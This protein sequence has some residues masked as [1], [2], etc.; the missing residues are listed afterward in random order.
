[1]ADTSHNA[2]ATAQEIRDRIREEFESS[3]YRDDV[4]N[5][6]DDLAKLREDIQHIGQHLRD[7]GRD[8]GKRA[9]DRAKDT[10]EHTRE[11]A[12]ELRD[13]G[14]EYARERIE[15]VERVA[16]EHPLATAAALL[17]AGVILGQLLSRGDRR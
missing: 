2:K 13:R 14:E 11:R 17:G 16:H 15:D 7:D 5:L 9:R 1:M 3:G 6:R 10:A 4:N 8:A 12:E